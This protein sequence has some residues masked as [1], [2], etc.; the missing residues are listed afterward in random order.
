MNAFMGKI[1]VVDL[2]KK[3]TRAVPV[4]EEVYRNF[5]SGKGLGAWYCYNNI[6]AGAD[7]LGPDNVLGFASGALTGTGALMCGRW[8]AVGKSPLTGGWGDSNCGGNLSP[9]IKQCGYDAIFFRG[10]SDSPVYLYCDNKGA[11]IRDASEY[12]GLDAVEAEKKLIEKTWARKKPRVACIGKAGEKLSLI[13]GICNDLGRIAARSGLGA[14][15]G[16]KRLKAIVLAGSKPIGVADRETIKAQSKKLGARLKKMNMPG[17]VPAGIT[18]AA[19][20]ILAKSGI[21]LGIDGTLLALFFRKWSTAFLT[22]MEITWGDGPI[23]NWSGSLK[24][25]KRKR[26]KNLNAGQLSGLELK[27]Y[28]CYSCCMGC[29]AVIDASRAT[30]GEFGETHKPEYETLQAFGALCLN[31]NLNSLIR[32]NELLN[33]AGMDSIS[34]GNT[35]AMAIEC[36]EAG[37]IGPDDADGLELRWGNADA[38]VKLVRMMIDREGIGDI[39]ADGTRR[40]AERIG[41]GAEKYAINVGG[42]EMGMHDGRGDPLLGLLYASEPAPGKHTIGMGIT[43]ASAGL[44]KF[45][46]W[47]PKEKLHFRAKEYGPNREIALKGVAMSSYSMLTDGLGGCMYAEMFGANRW[48]PATYMNAAAGW[49]LTN[50]DYM[51]IGKRIQTVRQLFN[52][53]QGYPISSA[54]IHSRASGAPALKEG[55]LKGKTLSNESNM[56][57]YWELYGWDPETGIPTE[58]TLKALGLDKLLA[59]GGKYAR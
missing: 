40:A 56:P 16:S 23:K 51:E 27:K 19:G 26:Y 10:A 31:D 8:T 54:K 9:A 30:D 52:A 35:V 12:W 17:F 14:V 44:H 50:E 46:D 42:A 11:E 53:K 22:G 47:A 34:A 21:M 37:I 29:G 7:P 43:Y 36:F 20:H 3:E 45:V 38:I 41:K 24:D 32:I 4:P 33:R 28:H 25:F 5:L 1:L 13:A 48:N 59:D 57:M 18:P 39:L 55:P 58:S 49:S 6:P 15:M 2:T